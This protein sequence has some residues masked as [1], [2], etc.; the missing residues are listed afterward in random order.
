MNMTKMTVIQSFGPG[1]NLISMLYDNKDYKELV[2]RFDSFGGYEK[3]R[4]FESLLDYV[5]YGFCLN[6]GVLAWDYSEEQT[7]RFHEMFALW[8]KAA[9]T[10]IDSNGWCDIPGN[11]HQ[12]CIYRRGGKGFLGQYFSPENLC[13][14]MARITM[15]PKID[16]GKS[17]YDCCCGSGR[18][19]L[20]SYKEAMDR[21]KHVYCA[22]KDIDLLCVKM[23]TANFL[24]HGVTGEV[25]W[26]DG[27]KPDDGR[28]CFLVNEGL[29]NPLSEY[30]GVP[31][32]R[33]ADFSETMQGHRA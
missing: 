1:N 8:V 14:C 15:S 16:D 17:V 32:C 4:I 22:A 2:R 33:I 27:L 30:F 10:E 9:K 3:V 19:L 23:C 7:R 21:K 20:A 18:M 12:S 26:G 29:N 24:L 31:H 6:G 13:S 11:L 5:I 28:T 25:V